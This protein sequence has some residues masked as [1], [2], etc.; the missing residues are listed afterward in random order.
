MN[1]IKI[2]AAFVLV[3]AAAGIQAQPKER[4]SLVV[5]FSRADENSKVGYV[6]EGNTAIIAKLIAQKMHADIFEIVPDLGRVGIPD[7]KA[8]FRF[9]A[10]IGRAH[11]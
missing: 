9:D 7:S 4:K 11:V 8:A 1:K 2:I 3:F 6:A 10:Q 5:Y